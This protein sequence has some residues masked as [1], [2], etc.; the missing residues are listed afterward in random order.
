MALGRERGWVGGGRRP[1]RGGSDGDRTL[2]SLDRPVRPPLHRRTSEQIALGAMSPAPLA[3]W[4]VYVASWHTLA[5]LGQPVKS[6]FGLQTRGFDKVKVEMAAKSIR[7]PAPSLAAGRADLKFDDFAKVF[8]VLKTNGTC[9]PLPPTVLDNEHAIFAP[10]QKAH[11][12]RHCKHEDHSTCGHA[13]CTVQIVAPENCDTKCAYYKLLTSLKAAGPDQRFK[14]LNHSDLRMLEGAYRHSIEYMID[15]KHV[16]EHYKSHQLIHIT[17]S[18]LN[19]MG[20]RAF[21]KVFSS[22]VGAE[23]LRDFGQNYKNA[24][25]LIE[26]AFSRQ[27]SESKIAIV[28]GCGRSGIIQNQAPISISIGTGIMGVV[29]GIFITVLVLL[30][31]N[32]EQVQGS[33]AK[34]ARDSGK[35]N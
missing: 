31:L 34:E 7:K 16:T 26:T 28:H 23:S 9:L 30:C 2:R 24:A 33:A 12:Q 25:Y 10:V 14:L 29:V 17:V 19:T 21:I 11:Q 27:E 35:I 6:A 18:P 13:C 5:A 22:S 15:A 32:G 8:P 20:D 1:K 3:F 4:V